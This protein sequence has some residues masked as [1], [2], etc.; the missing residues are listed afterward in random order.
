[1]YVN[2]KLIPVKTIPGTRGGGM[3]DSSGR[4]EFKNDRFDTL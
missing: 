3:R 2:A 1:V 4:G